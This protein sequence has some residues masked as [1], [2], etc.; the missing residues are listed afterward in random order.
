MC[1]AFI[2]DQC[3]FLGSK[4]S[5]VPDHTGIEIVDGTDVCGNS[6][7]IGIHADQS[8]TGNHLLM[9]RG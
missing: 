2:P 7:R 8:D 9:E 3:R 1:D 4:K 6:G 5:M